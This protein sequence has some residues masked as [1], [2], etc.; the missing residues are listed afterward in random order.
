MVQFL[1]KDKQVELQDDHEVIDVQKQ[2][3]NQDEHVKKVQLGSTYRDSI[4]GCYK[5]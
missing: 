1:S 5:L 2:K 3:K 4:D